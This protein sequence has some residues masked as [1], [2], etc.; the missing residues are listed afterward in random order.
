MNI[1][2][3]NPGVCQVRDGVMLLFMTGTL[4]TCQCSLLVLESCTS[5][6]KIEL[7]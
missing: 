1:I 6:L 3:R 4:P 7:L 5:T 2:I